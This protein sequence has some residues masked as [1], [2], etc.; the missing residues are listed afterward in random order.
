V[1]P[2]TRTVPVE[3]L[4]EGRFALDER[5]R[6]WISGGAG[7]RLSN[8]YGAPDFRAILA[9]GGAWVP[10]ANET[11][12]RVVHHQAQA[13]PEGDRD[14]DGIPDATD[15]CPSVPED[16]LAPEPTD[17][18]PKP[19]DRDKDGIDDD[20]DKCP[21]QPEDFDGIDDTDGCPEDD[22]DADGIP[23]AEDACPR[24]PGARST[25][26]AKN[27]CK[28]GDVVEPEIVLL[29]RVTFDVGKSTLPKDAEA[30]LADVVA[31]LEAAPQAK[32]VLVVG[33]ADPHEPAFRAQA[34][35]EA[36]AQSVVAWLVAH[37]VAR[38]RLQPVG[39][40]ATAPASTDKSEAGRRQN[41]RVEFVVE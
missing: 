34:L 19:P 11:R 23:D 15:L 31:D 22:V 6:V 20:H 32:R 16:G 17:G 26:P 12:G 5:Q 21:S 30:V 3:W 28:G 7:T 9:I 29:E 2:G 41:R 13:R 27:G 18:C 36:R 4:G 1:S 8:G 25:D 33:H 10:E 24:V 37:G 40:A 39:K 14:D 35:S 38:E